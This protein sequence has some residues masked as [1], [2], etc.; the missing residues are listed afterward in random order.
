MCQYQINI[1]KEFPKELLFI[2]VTI[3]PPCVIPNKFE[4]L[5]LKIILAE[6]VIF[7][8]FAFF[9]TEILL[10]KFEKISLKKPDWFLKYFSLNLSYSTSLIVLET[11]ELSI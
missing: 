9:D 10:I 5:S 2:T 7:L 3:P 11:D 1:S 4:D 8:L 6:N